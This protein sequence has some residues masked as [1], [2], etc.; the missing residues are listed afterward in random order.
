MIDPATAMMMLNTAS[1]LGANV[2]MFSQNAQNMRLQRQ[3]NQFNNANNWQMFLAQRIAALNDWNRTNQ[4]N[5]P[6][7]Q[8][9]RFKEAG[10]NPHLIY[11]QGNVAQ[12][13]RSSSGNTPDLPAPQSNVDYS[14]LMAVPS[15]ISQ[16]YD[17]SLKKQSLDNLKLQAELIAAQVADKQVDVVN[18]TTLGEQKRWDLELKKEQR[19]TI[20]QEMILRNQRMESDIGMNS[21]KQYT[22]RERLAQTDRAL[23]QKDVAL[24]LQSQEV[25]LKR[26]RTTA[27]MQKVASDIATQY[28]QR[29]LMTSNMTKTDREAANLLIQ[30][31]LMRVDL[32]LRQLGLTP[33]TPEYI[34]RYSNMVKQILNTVNPLK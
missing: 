16:Y 27:D 3:T 32:E 19:D 6:Q 2:G 11:G 29:N 12:P 20:V 13:I 23:D 7:Q 4:Y 1:Q 25:Q 24:T 9:Q 18:K 8:M 22:D 34:N 30:R 28:V 26:A 5:S 14:Q 33:G 15:A 17:V 21:W 10:L 31:E